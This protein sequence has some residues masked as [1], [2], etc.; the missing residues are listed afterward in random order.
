MGSLEI[1]EV[2]GMEAL[3]PTKYQQTTKKS[4]T[5]Q[6]KSLLRLFKFTNNLRDLKCK[7]NVILVI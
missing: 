4:E 7:V 3:N 1:Q 6:N 2:L 5:E